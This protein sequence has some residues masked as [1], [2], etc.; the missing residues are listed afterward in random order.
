MSVTTVGGKC[1]TALLLNVTML[2]S[3]P[4]GNMVMNCVKA[5]CKMSQR[6][7]TDIDLLRSS[8]KMYR[9]FFG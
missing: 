3:D 7:L 9:L 8:T 6:S 1:M 5:L 2:I 4:N